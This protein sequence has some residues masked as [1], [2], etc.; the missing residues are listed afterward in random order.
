LAIS[1]VEVLL[2]FSEGDLIPNVG[3]PEGRSIVERW[4]RKGNETI[5]ACRKGEYIYMYYDE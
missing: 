5:L 3:L 2:L 4:V 1:R